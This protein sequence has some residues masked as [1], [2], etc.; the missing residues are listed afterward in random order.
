MFVL[1]NYPP[2]KHGGKKEAVFDITYGRN[3]FLPTRGCVQGAGCS[4]GHRHSSFSYKTPHVLYQRAR[5]STALSVTTRLSC[6]PSKLVKTKD[7]ATAE[8]FVTPVPSQKSWFCGEQLTEG[9][10]PS[11][12]GEQNHPGTAQTICCCRQ[13]SC[14]EQETA[15]LL[16]EQ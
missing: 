15:T 7:V 16:T 3:V 12:Q 4:D 8:G 5:Q 1:P 11:I 9:T 14:N 6:W 10:F 2:I 13:P